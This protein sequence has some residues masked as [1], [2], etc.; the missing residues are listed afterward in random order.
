MLVCAFA[1]SGVA[2]AGQL[3]NGKNDRKGF[4]LGF[5]VGGGGMYMTSDGSSETKGALITD[6]KIGAGITEDILLM[7]NQYAGYTKADGVNLYVLNFPVALQWYFWKDLYV[8][9]AVGLSY[10]H[11]STN[12]GGLTISQ[13][14]KVSFGASL[15]AGYEFRFGKYFALSPEVT[16]HYDRIRSDASGNAHAFGAEASFVW[17]F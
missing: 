13:N 10:A 14:S 17:F 16:Y 15:S 8:R 6:I 4:L 3:E 11:A 9:P 5:G 1:V 7:Y 2:N 12:V